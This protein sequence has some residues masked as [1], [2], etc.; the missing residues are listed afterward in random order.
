MSSQKPSIFFIFILTIILS[1]AIGLG[2]TPQVLI[3]SHLLP[4]V[5]PEMEKPEF[6]IKKIQNPGRL[7]LTPGEIRKLNEE[8]LK[9]E[10]LFLCRVKDLKEE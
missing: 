4:N 1:L 2:C 10:D 8:N 9:R 5:S 7:L 6:W 3:A